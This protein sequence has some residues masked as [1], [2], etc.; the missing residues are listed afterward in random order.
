MRPA[1][2]FFSTAISRSPD[3][4]RIRSLAK[5]LSPAAWEELYALLLRTGLMSAYYLRLK[6]LQVPGVPE[7]FLSRLKSQMLVNMTRAGTMAGEARLLMGE[8]A[9]AG[10]DVLPLKGPV[11]GQY[12][13]G[14]CTLRRASVDL[15]FLVHPRHLEDSAACLKAQG[16]EEAEKDPLMRQLQLS[17][18][19]HVIYMAQGN[20]Q[21]RNVELHISPCHSS[22]AADFSQWPKRS[23]CVDF[24]GEAVRLFCDED[25]ALYLAFLC[26]PCEE[27]IE[28]RYLYD[29]HLLLE[30]SAGTID[31]DAVLRGEGRGCQVYFALS[32]CRSLFN[33]PVPQ[34]VMAQAAPSWM[35]RCMVHPWV[36]PGNILEARDETQGQGYLF[37]VFWKYLAHNYI[38]RKRFWE[39]TR[40]A[41]SQVF[42]SAE[43]LKAHY[44]GRASENPLVMYA[45]RA[46]Y[47]AARVTGMRRP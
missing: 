32:L 44:H 31:W 22:I 8:F 13:W 36:D 5:R 14:D 2:L 45:R 39:A 17:R 18:S 26:F 24:M 7:N 21:G 28:A 10:L 29:M 3:I 43:R 34:K 30:K 47:A 33:S 38:S 16:Y 25:L 1:N 23:R 15:D 12:L 37:S 40:L 27:Y 6:Q 20:G 4:R 35:R 19:S 46:G 9:A 41:M 11:L 42:P